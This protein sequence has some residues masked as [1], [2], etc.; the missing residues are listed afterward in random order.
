M[1]KLQVRC[2]EREIPTYLEEAK[3]LPENHSRREKKSLKSDV[4]A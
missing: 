3:L 2:G 1:L 4:K